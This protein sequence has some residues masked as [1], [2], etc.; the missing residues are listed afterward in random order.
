MKS[1][2][3]EA[4]PRE[5]MRPPYDREE[6]LCGDWFTDDAGNMVVRVAADSLDDDQAFLYALHELVEARLCAKA[7]VSQEA[8]DAF[9]REYKGD[10]E[11]GGAAD[12][13]YR[14]QHRQACLVEFLVADM[15]GLL[16]Y[17]SMF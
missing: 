8:V 17:G 1:I 16:G 10:G 15:L 3:L 9:D 4:V 7:G 2:L 12:C 13:V 5:Q 14:R 6:G 11:P